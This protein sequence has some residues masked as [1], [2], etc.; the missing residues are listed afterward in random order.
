MFNY[1][2]V[3]AVAISPDSRWAVSGA[4]DKSLYVWDLD[5]GACVVRL[6]V[7]SDVSSC[8]VCPDSRS[9]I[10]GDKS[11]QMHFLRLE[12]ANW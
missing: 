4:G 1:M 12:N 11:G 2:D 3:N 9:I 6:N 5:S 10:A 7:D 8:A